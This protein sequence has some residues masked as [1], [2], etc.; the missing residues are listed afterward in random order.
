MNWTTIE[1]KNDP[2]ILMR[3]IADAFNDSRE[4]ANGIDDEA[5]L[6]LILEIDEHVM[7]SFKAL[8]LVLDPIDQGFLDA[9]PPDLV[10][11]RISVKVQCALTAAY[12]LHLHDLA[13]SQKMLTELAEKTCDVQARLY[14]LRDWMWSDEQEIWGN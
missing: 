7:D 14:L 5:G 4:L 12:D 13:L 6:R 1:E 8:D 3:K 11:D 10:I 9:I 2:V